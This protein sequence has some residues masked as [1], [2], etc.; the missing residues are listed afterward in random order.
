MHSA[1]KRSGPRP[2][3]QQIALATERRFDA[4]GVGTHVRSNGRFNS[5]EGAGAGDC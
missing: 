5:I 3:Q 4:A 1:N 2:S